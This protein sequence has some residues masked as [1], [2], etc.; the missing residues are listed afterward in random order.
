MKVLKNK[1]LGSL[2]KELTVFQNRSTWSW[3][4]W[5]YCLFAGIKDLEV[6]LGGKKRLIAVGKAYSFFKGGCG[7]RIHI[8][9]CICRKKFS[10]GTQMPV[11]VVLL[12]VTNGK[13]WKQVGVRLCPLYHFVRLRLMQINDLF[14]KQ[15]VFNWRGKAF[16]YSLRECWHFSWLFHYPNASD[17]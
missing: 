13:G 5:R 6:T 9:N 7:V 15:N 1:S 2:V 3:I 16:G 10:K 17:T 4:W 11:N 8:H 12:M 14:T